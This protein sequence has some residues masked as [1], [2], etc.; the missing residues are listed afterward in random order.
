MVSHQSPKG[1]D[2][3]KG[4]IAWKEPTL[5]EDDNLGSDCA[6]DARALRG[7]VFVNLIGIYKAEHSSPYPT[8]RSRLRTWHFSKIGFSFVTQQS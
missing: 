2:M 8:F 1:G 4:A 3:L 5:T 6:W 7:A